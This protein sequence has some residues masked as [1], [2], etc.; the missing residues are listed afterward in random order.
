MRAEAND[1][2]IRELMRQ[3][4][5][6]AR[7]PARVYLVGGATA[8]LCGWRAS[9]VDVD[10]RFVPENRDLFEALPALKE[11]LDVNIE[12]AW[13]SQFLPELPG[14]EDR[15]PW[16]A[17]FGRV[18]FHHYDPYSQLLAK[19]ERGHDR[20]R[21]DVAALLAGEWIDRDRAWELYLSIEPELIR[22]P[23]LEP[24]TVRRKIEVA[25]GR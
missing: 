8:V 10:L 17:T 2:R 24:I 13:P 14:W 15:S 11:S 25:L 9:T 3:L 4:G 21:I 18:H 6:R 20:D 22:Y 19:I 5:D 12:L 16:I 23:A 7:L 1:H